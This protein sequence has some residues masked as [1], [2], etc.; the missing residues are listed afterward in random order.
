LVL[1]TFACRIR[2]NI[3][4]H[5]SAEFAP[6]LSVHFRIYGSK[7]FFATTRLPEK[8]GDCWLGDR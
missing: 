3:E 5:K 4:T 8:A 2:A 6:T 1:K 7:R